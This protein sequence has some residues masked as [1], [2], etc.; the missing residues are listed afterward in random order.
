MTTA[1]RR[2]SRS[3]VEVRHDGANHYEGERFLE[4]AGAAPCICAILA[5]EPLPAPPKGHV[6]HDLHIDVRRQAGAKG[7]WTEVKITWRDV[8]DKGHGVGLEG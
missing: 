5:A 8:P 4:Y 1:I 3:T 6:R 7:G 2:T